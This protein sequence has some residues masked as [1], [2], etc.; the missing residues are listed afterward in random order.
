MKFVFALIL[1]LSFVAHAQT[2]REQR[3]NARQEKR[4]AQGVANGS[5]TSQEQ[6]NINAG[7]QK[8]EQAETAAAADG[9]VSKKEKAKIERMQ[10]RQS[11]KIYRK[12][13]N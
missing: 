1:A 6:A 3:R 12:K 7:Q 11:R 13:H 5:L 10:D 9:T 4:E 8:V 2:A